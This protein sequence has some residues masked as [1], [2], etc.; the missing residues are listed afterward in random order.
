MIDIK[1]LNECLY[2]HD[3]ISDRCYILKQVSGS[4]PCTFHRAF[5]LLREPVQQLETVI[6]LGYSRVLTRFGS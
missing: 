3:N 2:I 4:L 6:F 5:D 1:F